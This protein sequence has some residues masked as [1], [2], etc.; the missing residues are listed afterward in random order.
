[1]TGAA[2]SAPLAIL[3]GSGKLTPPRFQ[4]V[5]R[6]EQH[7]L[8]ARAHARP[9]R[10]GLTA[11]PPCAASTR[12]TRHPNGRAHRLSRVFRCLDERLTKQALGWCAYVG[13]N[14]LRQHRSSTLP[15]SATGFGRLTPCPAFGHAALEPGPADAT[16]FYTLVSS[17]PVARS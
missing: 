13:W 16:L 6:F 7:T 10:E 15:A 11:R 3:W 5:L 2:R 12:I 17:S 14:H 4:N 9:P 1:M 8:S